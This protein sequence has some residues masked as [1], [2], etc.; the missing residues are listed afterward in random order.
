MKIFFCLTLVFSSIAVIVA[1]PVQDMCNR[2]LDLLLLGYYGTGKSTLV[3]VLNNLCDL[4]S[5][6]EEEIAKTSTSES[7][8]T[9]ECA[10]YLC[11]NGTRS[12]N[13]VDT[14]G[15]TDNEN[16]F[17]QI[18][19]QISDNVPVLLKQGIDA[20]FVLS[21]VGRLSD[22]ERVKLINFVKSLITEEGYGRGFIVF[23]FADNILID[24]SK[25]AEKINE[26]KS[27]I[28]AVAPEAENFLNAVQFMFYRHSV[29][30][31]KI[32]GRKKRY[33]LEESRQRF[34][35]ETYSKIH[36]N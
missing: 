27:G 30:T 22:A 36:E 23:T 5:G 25:E 6:D 2:P 13:I 32:N 26:F 18:S 11:T 7:L 17:D 4:D 33:S 3:N 24:E 28:L 16:E 31:E 19:T 15:F 12:L 35:R 34:M 9:K 1:P 21:P 29:A 14:P 10:N 20:F 8:C